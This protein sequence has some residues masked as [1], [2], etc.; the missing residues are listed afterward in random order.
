MGPN[1]CHKHRLRKSHNTIPYG[2]HSLPQ[3]WDF[4][5]SIATLTTDVSVFGPLSVADTLGV[6]A[7]LRKKVVVLSK[8]GI[9]PHG[10]L[11][12]SMLDLRRSSITTSGSRVSSDCRHED[13]IT[14]IQKFTHRVMA[15][16]INFHQVVV[17]S[18]HHIT[19]RCLLHDLC[20]DR[21]YCGKQR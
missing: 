3:F 10:T 14:A 1:V 8:V 5:D 9:S 12:I 15:E 2:M 13:N 20:Q 16:S 21:A 11:C 6:E 17:M 18:E 19:I 4:I 7:P